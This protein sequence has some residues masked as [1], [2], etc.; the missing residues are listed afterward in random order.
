MW[1]SIWSLSIQ[2]T[3]RS[4]VFFSCL[5]DFH[6][7]AKH[8]QS[9]ILDYHL[10]FTYH[11]RLSSNI[12]FIAQGC[13]IRDVR[14]KCHKA[15]D[16]RHWTFTTRYLFAFFAVLGVL[17]NGLL[18]IFGRNSL[19]KSCSIFICNLAAE[20]LAITLVALVLGFLRLIA[21][22]MFRRIIVIVSWSTRLPR[23]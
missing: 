13:N 14:R 16:R 18:L 7:S 3:L 20:D 17:L 4:S 9:I 22:K 2:N 12:L 10:S 21:C 19:P 6:C 8:I 5:S 11:S 15:D 1:I 23:S